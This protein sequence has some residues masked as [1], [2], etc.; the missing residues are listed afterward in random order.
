MFGEGF[1][2]SEREMY[3]EAIYGKCYAGEFEPGTVI[4]FK[5]AV[6]REPHTAM[7]EWVAAPTHSIIGKP[8]VSLRYIMTEVDTKTGLPYAVASHRIDGVVAIASEPLLQECRWCGGYRE[9]QH[10][11]ECLLKPKDE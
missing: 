6:S 7:I 5:D 10:T 1:L 4:R 11:D 2:F 3:L 9:A 8:D